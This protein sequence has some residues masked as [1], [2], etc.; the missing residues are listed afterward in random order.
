MKKLF[1]FVFFGVLPIFLT[2]Q[3]VYLEQKQSGVGIAG[4]FSSNKNAS[5][6]DLGIGF[7]FIGRIDLA[8]DYSAINFKEKLEGEAVTA[9]SF[10]LSTEVFPVK[11][12]QEIPLSL[13]LGVGVG[14][15][16]YDSVILDYLGWE[17]SETSLSLGISIHHNAKVTSSFSLVPSAGF[18]YIKTTLSIEDSYGNFVEESEAYTGVGMGMGLLFSL[19]EKTR[20]LLRP[21]V[22]ILDNE[23]TFTLVFGLL[24]IF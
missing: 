7:A 22:F 18:S 1:T 17:M 4:G 3:S 13:G 21:S 23:P 14:F 24:G 2:A 8:L 10:Q 9:Y 16:S 12:T 6:F 19:Q 11:Q 15:A 20:L 5:S